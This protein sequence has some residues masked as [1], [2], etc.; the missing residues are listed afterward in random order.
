MRGKIKDVAVIGAA[1]N[2]GEMPINRDV[3]FSPLEPRDGFTV[4]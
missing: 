3:G 4:P 2:D 1:I